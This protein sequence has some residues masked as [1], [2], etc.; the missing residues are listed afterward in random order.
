MIEQCVV[1][2]TFEE[3]VSDAVSATTGFHLHTSLLAY[4]ELWGKLKIAGFQKATFSS[5]HIPPHPPQVSEA[6]LDVNLLRGFEINL[7]S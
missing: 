5:C 3:R 2:I 1:M 6:S 7:Y 4:V